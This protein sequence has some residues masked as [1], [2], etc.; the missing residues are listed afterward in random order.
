MEDVSWEVEGGVVLGPPVVG[1]E[2]VL[3]PPV[4]E[5]EVVLGPPDV[6]G[7]GVAD[8]TI[9]CGEVV[10]GEVLVCELQ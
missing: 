5:D 1:G 8:V 3:G 6:G 7:V 10:V 4:V 9:G 2:V